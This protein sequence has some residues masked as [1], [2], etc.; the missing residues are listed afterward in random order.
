VADL[1][2]LF[3]ESNLG[4]VNGASDGPPESPEGLARRIRSLESEGYRVD[5]WILH[6]GESFKSQVSSDD[7]IV[8][9]LRGT[10]RLALVGE[11]ARDIQGGD[12]VNLPHG[13][14]YGL[15]VVGDDDVYTLVASRTPPSIPP[16]EFRRNRAV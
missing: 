7:R 4:D 8:A 12:V 1:S 16:E 3:G 11:E 2:N 6:A 9:V 10:L 5:T 14:V 15:S 13:L